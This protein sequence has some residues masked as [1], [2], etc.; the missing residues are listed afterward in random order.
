MGARGPREDGRPGP[1]AHHTEAP[2]GHGRLL[3]TTPPCILC[4]L[5]E[6]MAHEE[7]EMRAMRLTGT[8]R[9]IGSNNLR[10]FL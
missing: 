6:F 10:L 2:S 8:G 1:E 3:G 5:S 9:E 7:E 4:W